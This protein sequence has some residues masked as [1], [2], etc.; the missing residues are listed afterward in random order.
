MTISC[1]NAMKP[2]WCRCWW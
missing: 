2:V 1:C